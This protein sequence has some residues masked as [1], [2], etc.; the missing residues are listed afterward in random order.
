MDCSNADTNFSGGFCVMGHILRH[1][2]YICFL[3]IFFLPRFTE[4]ILKIRHVVTSLPASEISPSQLYTDKYCPR[5]EMENRIKEQQLELFADRTS[6]QTFISNQLRLWLSSMTYV[7]MQAFRY[8]CLGK[9][10]F[11]KAT[12]GTIA[13]RA[14][15]RRHIKVSKLNVKAY[16]N[17]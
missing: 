9:T 17:M 13:L 16:K 3:F 14:A 8:H 5:G 6:T 2:P 12:V 15:A 4:R 11:S 10:S 7:L 1:I